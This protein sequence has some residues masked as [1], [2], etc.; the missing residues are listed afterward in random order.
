MKK[1]LRIYKDFAD[2]KYVLDSLKIMQSTKVK[3]GL[4]GSLSATLFKPVSED[5]YL[6]LIM[7]IQIR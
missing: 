1:A 7:P 6:C 5:D 2:Y 3:I 4:G